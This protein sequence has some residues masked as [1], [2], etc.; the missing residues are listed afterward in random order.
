M[1]DEI[2]K[3]T[4]VHW[5]VKLIDRVMDSIDGFG[6]KFLSGRFLAVTLDTII[7][8]GCVVL[9]GYLVHSKILEPE[10]FIAVIGGYALL[11]KETRL[12]YFDRTDRNEPTKTT[13]GKT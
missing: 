1:T 13:E 9:C 12:K 2:Q 8:P 11:V 5:S 3:D 4:S 10:T 7:Y 6:T